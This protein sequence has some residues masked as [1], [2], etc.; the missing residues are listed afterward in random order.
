MLNEFNM[1]AD[2]LEI[3]KNSEKLLEERKEKFGKFLKKKREWIYYLVLG[4]WSDAGTF[5][6][7]KVCEEFLRGLM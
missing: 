4:F 6:S 1:N 5:E 2:D 3:S 7:R